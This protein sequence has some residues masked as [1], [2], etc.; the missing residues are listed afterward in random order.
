MDAEQPSV[1]RNVEHVL[2]GQRKAK[3]GHGK[4]PY[5]VAEYSQ[6]L[7]NLDIWDNMFF[8]SIWGSPTVY[9]F[10]I[11]PGLVLDIGCGT[12]WWVMNMAQRW[13]NTLFVGF[14]IL[15]IQPRL[16]DFEHFLELTERISWVHGNFLDD[17]PFPDDHFDYVRICRAALAIP[18]DE[19]V[20]RVMRPGGLFEIIEEDPIFPSPTLPI[21]IPKNSSISSP[22]TPREGSQETLASSSSGSGETIS[23]ERLK[24][25]NRSRLS[26]FRSTRS[27]GK[28]LET[29]KSR[30]RASSSATM[31]PAT[32]GLSNHPQNH[33]KLKTAWENMLTNRFISNKI[34]SILPFYL[35]TIFSGVEVFDL[36]SVPLPS[37]TPLDQ[38]AAEDDSLYSIPRPCNNNNNN[39][40]IKAKNGVTTKCNSNDNNTVVNYPI[41]TELPRLQAMDLHELA[42]MHLHYTVGFIKACKDAIRQEYRMLFPFVE[43]VVG[44][45]EKAQIPVI[46]VDF[47]CSEEG[48]PEQFEVEW[49]DWICDME[50]RMRLRKRMNN[51][52]AWNEPCSPRGG[53]PVW[54]HWR[55]AIDQVLAR[56]DKSVF[57]FPTDPDNLCRSVKAYMGWKAPDNICRFGE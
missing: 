51:Q 31:S 42:G 17:F 25:K 18:E 24:T 3:R 37:N 47:P 8:E 15:E 6:D 21:P 44:P 28:P 19:Q 45:S 12:G 50:D 16:R 2:V 13:P 43:G 57:D 26:S 54:R 48:K 56:E 46:G 20:R 55:K 4:V 5:P 41:Q 27:L 1:V 33:T 7:A 23:E 32:I 10:P 53:K 38:D 40:D 30:G 35:S 34:L 39:N 29:K 22:T 11:A 14:D 52:V 49:N 9:N 36:Y